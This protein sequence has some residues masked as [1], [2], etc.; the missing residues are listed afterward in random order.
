[1]SNR[2]IGPMRDT[3]YHKGEEVWLHPDKGEPQL[4]HRCRITKVDRYSGF[5][6]TVLYDTDHTYPVEQKDKPT[7]MCKAEGISAHWFAPLSAINRL[8]ELVADV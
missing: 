6:Q 3:L 2:L 7:K 4:R 1:M 8:G 5:G